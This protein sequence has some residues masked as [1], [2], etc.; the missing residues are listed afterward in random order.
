MGFLKSIAKIAAPVASIAGMATG[1]PGLTAVGSVLGG[2]N[3]QNNATQAAATANEFTKEMYQNRYQWQVEDLKKAGLNPLL[4]V[5]QGAPPAGAGQKAETVSQADKIN[6]AAKT[7]LEYRMSAEQIKN[8]QAQT[9]ASTAQ[10]AKTRAETAAIGGKEVSGKFWKQA[11]DN[12]LSVLDGLPP[13]QDW[14]EM[15]GS[16][17]TNAYNKLRTRDKVMRVTVRPSDRRPDS[18]KLGPPAPGTYIPMPPKP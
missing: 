7:A 3:D 12:A 15:V 8:I 5:S 10:A 2:I 11:G 13:A 17:A 9:A 16:S 6:N 18:R 4:S 14:L 1:N